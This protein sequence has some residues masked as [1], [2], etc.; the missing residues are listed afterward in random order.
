MDEKRIN[1]RKLPVGV[2]DF[3]KIRRKN[4]ILVDKTEFVYRLAHKTTPFFLSRPRRFGKS[5]LLSTMK[6]YWEGRKDLFEGLAIERL[7]RDN[8]DAWKQYP[9]FYMDFDA[10]NYCVEG[11][12]EA[13]LNHML[14]K[15]EK[16]YGVAQGD[17][18]LAGRFGLL[19]ETAYE[20]TGLG[21][22]V[23]VD[24]YDKS[25]LEA[26][27]NPSLLEHNKAVLKGFFGNLKS[28]DAY[29]EFIFITGVT[30]FH[31]VSIFSDLNNLTDISLAKEY[32]TICGFTQQ[33][34]E[35]AYGTEIEALA[36]ELGTDREEC[37]RILKEQ[38]D[39]YRFHKNGERVYNP[40]SLLNAFLAKELSSYWYE[41][42]TPNFLVKCL[43]EIGFDIRKFTDRTLYASRALLSDYT[44]DVADPVPLL[45][46]SGYL[47]IRDYDKEDDIYQLGFPNKEVE[48]A[49]LKSL[50]PEYV[51]SSQTGLGTDVFTLSRHVRNGDVDATMRVLTALFA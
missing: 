16:A 7:E 25:L 20:Q 41:T 38:Y 50:L 8:P 18:T 27:G 49:F 19:L 43:K 14:K 21:C 6:S 47:T 1:A 35:D 40:Y 30:K 17:E 12:L 23:L 46:Q 5:L 45:Y 22:V 15:W 36:Q 48:N 44:D 24:E 13:R 3:E 28:C 2:Q 9:V 51:P 11:G 29:I 32:A 4:C 42:G 33:E 26:M 39:G 10:E 31:K 34:V 37:L